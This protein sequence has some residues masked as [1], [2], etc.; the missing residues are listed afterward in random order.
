METSNS[1][2]IQQS[3]REARDHICQ[4]SPSFLAPYTP[5]DFFETPNK[6]AIP[7]DVLPLGML[8]ISGILELCRDYLRYIAIPVREGLYSGTK[9]D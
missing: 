7:L 3:V 4:Q 1:M 9:P 5:R 8:L 2:G 6:F